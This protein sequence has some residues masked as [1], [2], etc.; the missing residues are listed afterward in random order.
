MN[1]NRM[2]M[3]ATLA[4]ASAA[5][6]PLASAQN[7][8]EAIRFSSSDI[9]GT[10]RYRSMAGAFGALGGDLSCMSD[11]P[12]GL[13]IFRGTNS[14]SITPHLGFTSTETLGSA[15]ETGKDNN[16]SVSNFG[17]VFSFM[18]EDD[19][20]LVNFNIGVGIE[21]RAQTFRKMNMELNRPM[22]SFGGYLFEQANS[23]LL[24]YNAEPSYLGTS[25]AWNDSHVPLLSLMGY[26]SYALDNDPDDDRFVTNPIFDNVYQKANMLERTRN[27]NY[28]I[29]A[30]ANFNDVLYAGITVR[31]T[32]FN[33]IVEHC[34]SEDSEYDMSGD[35]ITYDNRVETKGSGIGVNLG[36]LW[37]PTEQWRIGAAVHTPVWTNMKE[38]TD[39]SMES[40]NIMYEDAYNWA[41]QHGEEEPQ[42]W[43]DYNGDYSYDF[44]TPWEYQFSTAYVIGTK[45]IV[46]LEYDLLDT[47]SMRFSASNKNNWEDKTFYKQLNNRQKDYLKAQHTI[48]AGV[49]YRI[50]P[51]FSLRAGY[52][53][54]SSPYTKEALFSD[55]YDG[56]D[57]SLLY[58]T[59]TKT[60]YSTLDGQYYI[61][62]GAGWRGKNWSIDLSCVSHSIKEYYSPYPCDFAD[63]DILDFNTHSLEWDLSF[64]YR[65]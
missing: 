30:A 8:V 14:I 1:A 34:F 45:A 53:Y 31:I 61:T 43:S 50:S 22:D 32:D 7:M 36:L 55:L 59:G 3:L 19:G 51:Q 39:A 29:S 5:Y 38:F 27:D 60:N 26:E 41:V 54:K 24:N 47:K 10:A 12:A 64:G 52:A 20:S 48:K 4:V 16:W 13:A 11:N 25:S 33:S 18:P 23:Y 35:F 44:S 37:K 15:K 58:R 42:N 40:F 21:R 63:S 62:G 49:E 65:F 56:E 2:T 28:N 57:V 9:I 17:A 6:S 46:S